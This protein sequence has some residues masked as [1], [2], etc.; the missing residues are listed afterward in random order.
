MNT[1]EKLIEAIRQAPDAVVEELFHFLQMTQ[2]RH[3]RQQPSLEATP[4]DNA[5]NADEPIET[6]DETLLELMERL[7]ADMTEEEIAQLPKDGAEQHDHY[8]YGSPK[9]PK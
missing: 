4:H 5:L 9:R 1:K 3:D 2:S 6:E 7:T 8:I